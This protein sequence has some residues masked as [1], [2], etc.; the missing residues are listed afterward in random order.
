MRRD[1]RP[2]T[3]PAPNLALYERLISDGLAAADSRGGV[4]DHVTARRMAIWLLS[5]PSTRTSP[6]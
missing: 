6:A 4:I 3:G 2:G 1:V 5:R